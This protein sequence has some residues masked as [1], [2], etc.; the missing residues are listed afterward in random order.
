MPR[1]NAFNGGDGLNTATHRWVRRTVAGPAGGTGQN[2]DA[3]RRKQFNIKI[4]HNFNTNHRLTGTWIRESHYSDN[5][6]LSP[7]PQGF[8]GEITEYPRVTTAQL[9]STLSPTLLNEFRFGYR[10]T[11]LHFTPPYHASKH[12][13]EAYDF[14]PQIN[15]Y[16]TILTPTLIGAAMVSGLYT[17][18]ESPLYTYADTLNW[19]KGSHAF[20]TGIEFRFASSRMWHGFGSA[21]PST[22]TGGAGDVPVRGID[23]ISG[24]LPSNITLAQN[25]L[26]GLSGSVQSIAQS[27]TTLEP[28]DTRFLDFNETYF[29]PRNPKGHFGRMR[30]THQN[31]FNF[32]IKDDWKVTPCFT[33]NLG[34]RYDLFRVPYHLSASGKNWTIGP[35][36]GAAGIFGYSGRSL[37]EAWMSGGGPRKGALT[38]FVLIGKDSKYPQQGLWPSDRNNF[39]PAVGFAWSP[40]W[41]GKDK[42]TVRGGYQIAYQLPGNSASWISVDVGSAPG[43]QYNPTDL[44]DGTFRD[45]TN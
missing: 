32:F 25:L 26:L 35:L 28:A 23:T 37:A 42:T 4:D 41:G 17:G 30:D 20:K 34:V 39:A 18:N 15:G 24:L 8:G 33:L 5:N 12:G 19:T 13:K 14:L 44:G 10:R 40:A 3:Y 2:V 27:F 9:T 38:E 6:Q 45:F 21:G 7:W 16:P 29:D 22:V 31:E 1:A 11:T 36:G 43:F